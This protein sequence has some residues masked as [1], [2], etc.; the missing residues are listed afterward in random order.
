MRKKLNLRAYRK[1]WTQDA[2]TIGPLDSTLDAWTFGLWTHGL[3]TTG[4]LDSGRLDAC[5]LDAWMTY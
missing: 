2:W 1:G 5:A 4:R 3:W